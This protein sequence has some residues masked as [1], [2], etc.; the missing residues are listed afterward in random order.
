MYI[1]TLRI[2]TDEGIQG[3]KESIAMDMEK[4]G[5]IEVVDVREVVLEQLR[6]EI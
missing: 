5:D 4:Y 6:M 1:I 3:I 2:N